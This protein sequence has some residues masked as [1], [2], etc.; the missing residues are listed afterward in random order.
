M[1][2]LQ[3]YRELIPTINSYVHTIAAEVLNHALMFHFN[4]QAGEF[5]PLSEC[6]GPYGPGCLGDVQRIADNHESPVIREYALGLL[7]YK[8]WHK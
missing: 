6:H 7:H 3:R 4:E 2:P 8:D 5:Y 1:R